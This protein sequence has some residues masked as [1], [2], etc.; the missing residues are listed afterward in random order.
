MPDWFVINPTRLPRT[1]VGG[2]STKTSMPGRTTG[3]DAHARAV[4]TRRAGERFMI[5][6]TCYALRPRLQPH[7]C[8]LLGSAPH[9]ERAGPGRDLD[10]RAGVHGQARG[11]RGDLPGRALGGGRSVRAAH[12]G[13]AQRVADGP[14]RV[15][16]RGAP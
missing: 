14:G 13:G 2:C 11:E 12:G 8:S 7:A 16:P 10:A 15:Y 4:A 5:S 1:S 9:S 6:V 3:A